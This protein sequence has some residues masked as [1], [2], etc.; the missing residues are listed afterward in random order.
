MT[1]TAS[2]G[3]STIE[4]RSGSESE[5]VL[6]LSS[7]VSLNQS[8]NPVQNL[9]SYKTIGLEFNFPVCKRVNAP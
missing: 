6:Y 8:T 4:K 7:I 5:M 3:V 1:L 2:S 9:E